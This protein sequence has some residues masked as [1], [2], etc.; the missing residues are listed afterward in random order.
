[1][2]AR[3]EITAGLVAGVIGGRLVGNPGVVVRDLGGIESPRAGTLTF[4]RSA[5]F[6]HKWASSACAAAL[7]SEGVEV[8]GHDPRSRALIYVPDADLA[9]AALL[10]AVTPKV[11]AP[12]GI[13]P[14]A[15]VDA[16][17]QIDPSA[18]VGAFCVI[19]AGVRVG[20]GVVLGAHSVLEPGATIGPRT[21]LAPRV[22]IGARCQ[23]GA[24]CDLASAAGAG[25]RAT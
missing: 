3:G 4:I 1:M 6:A 18:S 2:L 9:V 17:A 19:G 11:K 21:V 23:V 20:P 5:G 13:H 25:P 24:D 15:V 22:T 7:V 8:P 12:A 14:S 10:K 16:S